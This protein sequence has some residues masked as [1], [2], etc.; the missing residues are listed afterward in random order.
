MF[1]TVYNSFES[2]SGGRDYIGKHSSENPY[3]S[4]LGSFKDTSFSPDNK[5]V[6]AYAKTAE[7]A[8][9]L[10][11]QYQK[12]FGVVED[13][14]FANKSF[15]STNKFIYG[16]TG[17]ANPSKRPEVREK[18]SKSKLG[19]KREDLRLRNLTNNP[20]KSREAR[21]KISKAAKRPR[22]EAEK[23]KLREFQ[24]GRKRSDETK[25]KIKEARGKQQPPTKGRSWWCHPDGTR[26]L[27]FKSPGEG[28]VKGKNW[29]G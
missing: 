7:G 4:Y 10:E 13:D 16:L 9:W 28:W 2:V 27:S 21:E 24:T 12:V 18:I 25:N 19:S 5:I 23:E 20:A 8:V 3:D 22:T 29:K 14:Q 11:I 17:D 6:L 15:Q 1:H 26:T